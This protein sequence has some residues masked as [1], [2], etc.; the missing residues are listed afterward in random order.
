MIIHDIPTSNKFYQDFYTFDYMKNLPAQGMKVLDSWPAACYMHGIYD[1][2]TI[3]NIQ[4]Q[5]RYIIKNRKIVPSR[6]LEIG[7]GQGELSCASGF[8]GYHIDTIDCNAS[9]A[10]FH[11]ATYRRFFDEYPRDNYNLFLTDLDGYTP[12][13]P[14]DINALVL[15]ESIEHIDSSEWKRFYLAILPIMKSNHATLTITNLKN[16]WPLGF[17]GDCIEHISLIDDDFYDNLTA[18]AR[19]VLYRDKSHICLEF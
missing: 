8:L 19:S 11:R 7:S 1:V 12:Y 16:Y 18:D 3:F 5:I 17:E 4:E 15:V 9:A 10:H 14:E 2:P 6:I 13:I